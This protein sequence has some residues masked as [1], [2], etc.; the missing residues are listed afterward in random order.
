MERCLA[1][2]AVVIW[3][4]EAPE[5]PG[6]ALKD[7]D[8][9]LTLADRADSGAEPPNPGV[10]PTKHEA[11]KQIHWRISGIARGNELALGLSRLGASVGV[12]HD[13]F[14]LVRIVEK[15]NPP[16]GSLA[17]PMMPTASQ[18]RQRSTTGLQIHHCPP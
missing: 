2:E 8:R 17:P 11:V 1:C 4:G 6:A 15:G 5:W 12:A 16:F 7:R 10:P 18:A 9:F 3:W 14:G 13:S